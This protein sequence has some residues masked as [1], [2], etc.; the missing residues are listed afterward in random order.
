MYFFYFFEGD[1][2]TSLKPISTSTG[3]VGAPELLGAER[4]TD[5]C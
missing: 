5:V 4:M 2:S 1:A 3:T